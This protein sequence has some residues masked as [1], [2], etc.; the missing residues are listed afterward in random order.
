MAMSTNIS[1]T[2]ANISISVVI[3]S[4]ERPDY[5]KLAVDSVLRQIHQPA[6]IIIIVDCSK[7]DYQPTLQSFS[8]ERIIY[9]RP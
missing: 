8:D 6:E 1:Q 9:H 2:Q 4:C 5:L 7:A 3:I